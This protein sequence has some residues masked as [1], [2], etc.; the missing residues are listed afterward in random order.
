MPDNSSPAPFAGIRPVRTGS[1]RFPLLLRVGG[2][3][4]GLAGLSAS[5]PEGSSG[6]ATRLVPAREGDTLRFRKQAMA[7]ESYES[8]G[9]ADV[10]GDGR[11]DL[12]SGCFWYQGPDFHKR[13]Y[14]GEVKRYG[15]YWDDFSTICMD[16]NGDGKP[17]FVT[18]GW[19][20]NS[21]RWRENP[22]NDQEWP[23]HVIAQTGNVESTRAWDVDGDGFAEIVPNTP[24]KPLAFYR[25][26]RDAS[27]KPLGR[28]TKVP[29][30]PTQGH[31]L[32]FGDVN[33]DGR[34]DFILG[35]GWLEAPPK[36]LAGAWNPHPE[37]DLGTASVP[38]LVVD[39]N[40]DGRNDLIAGQGHGYGLHWYEQGYNKSNKQ[41]T[42]QKHAIDSTGSQFHT[43]EWVDLD[44]DQKPELLTGKRYRAHNDN[45]PGAYDPVGLYYYQWNG[46]A[47]S[48]HVI[49]YGPYGEGKGTGI[50]MAVADLR[51]TGRKDIV[52]AG[53]DG[54]YVFFNEGT[55]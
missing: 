42:W 22:G 29:V 21:V 41:R 9:V 24:G 50:F 18:G 11:P 27:Q 20:G 30:A 47:F 45:D 35:N 43:M 6:G 37:F 51:G 31:G 49:S 23:E 38:V 46:R 2:L 26:E 7:W 12:L 40:G 8:V 55:R 1:A 17:D 4:L 19:W 15:E 52:V 36:P 53:K 13:H 14:L 39:V 3:L 54:L 10:N 33:G 5:L 34:G 32:G 16:V 25:L 48:K 28:F 44:G